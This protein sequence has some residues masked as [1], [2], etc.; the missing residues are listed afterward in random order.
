[1]NASETPGIVA[2]RS[3]PS[4]R[5]DE[6]ERSNACRSVRSSTAQKIR[7]NPAKTR[8]SHVASVANSPIGEYHASRRSW[9]SK[10]SDGRAITR[11]T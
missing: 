5:S 6:P 8:V 9:R 11:N 1:M 10:G 7:P 2:G 3:M 4:V